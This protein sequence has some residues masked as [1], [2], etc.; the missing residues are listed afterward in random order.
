MNA[1]SEAVGFDYYLKKLQE[2]REGAST[3]AQLKLVIELA[4]SRGTMPLLDLASRSKMELRVFMDAIAKMQGG[5]LIALDG[6]PE[7]PEDICVELT[8]AGRRL[9]S[10]VV[11]RG[12]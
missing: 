9:A 11:Q 4:K 7:S 5:D 12:N 10:I 2:E 6:T 1:A 8:P 3:D